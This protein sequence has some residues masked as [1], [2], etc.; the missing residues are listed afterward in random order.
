MSRGSHASFPLYA[1]GF[2]V[3]PNGYSPF[4]QHWYIHGNSGSDGYSGKT[5]DKPF[6]TLDKLFDM[7]ASAGR[8]KAAAGCYIHMLGNIIE[9][10]TMPLQVPDV[11]FMGW[12][13]NPRHADTHPG[14]G[15]YSGMTWKSAGTASALLT[16][17]NPAVSFH[18]ILFVAHASHPAILMERNATETAAGE[19]DSSHMKVVG[20][21]F[22]SGGYGIR[23]TGGTA[24]VKIWGNR[25]EALTECILGVG[26]IGVGQSD[27]DIRDNTFDGMTNGVKIAGFGCRIQN[28]TFSDGG[29]PDTTYVLNT[30]NGGGSDNHVIFNSFQTADAQY[31]TPDLVGCSTDVWRNQLKDATDKSGTP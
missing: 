29:T 1:G 30:N 8:A 22:A 17:R 16:L 26:N 11:R 5:P 28:N 10:L 23:D 14:N 12:G 20:C 4:A 3:M 24:N 9:H 25:F 7:W 19:H 21:R 6:A 31:S 15:Q 27:W 13:N 2:P 18:N